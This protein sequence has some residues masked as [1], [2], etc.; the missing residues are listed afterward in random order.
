[1]PIRVRSGMTVPSGSIRLTPSGQVLAT[2][3]SADGAR[4]QA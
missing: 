2:A 3:P 4:T 1:V